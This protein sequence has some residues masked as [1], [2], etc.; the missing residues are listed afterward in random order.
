MIIG[1][2]GRLWLSINLHGEADMIIIGSQRRLWLS[3]ELVRRGR[4]HWKGRGRT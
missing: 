4:W 2:Q 1:N 3:I